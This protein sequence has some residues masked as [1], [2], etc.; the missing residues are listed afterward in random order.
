MSAPLHAAKT[1]VAPNH[2]RD[3]IEALLVRHGA[4]A[5]A[6]GM[7]QEQAQISFQ[8][9]ERV[10]RFRMP[11]PDQSDPSITRTASGKL[12]TGAQIEEQV[13]QAIRQRW[14]ALLLLV[15]AK[16]E[17]VALGVTTIEEEFLAWTVMP[18]GRTVGEHVR[19]AIESA[20]RTGQTPEL[21]EHRG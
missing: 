3:Q 20:Y 5:F 21:L 12:R 8:I 15:R 6:Y 13:M 16:L 19:P 1:K 9:G 10:V 4:T 18:D 2:T 11:W 17:S 7:T 14:R